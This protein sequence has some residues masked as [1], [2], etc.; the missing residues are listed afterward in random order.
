[1]SKRIQ[2]KAPP[3]VTPQLQEQIVTQE[4]EYTLITPLFGG[5]AIAGERD[6]VTVVRGTEIRGHLRFWWRACYGGRYNTVKEMK[7]DEDRIWGAAAHSKKDE[8]ERADAEQKKGKEGEKPRE[9]TVQITVETL[10]EG[11]PIGPFKIKPATR[12]ANSK[13]GEQR[14][15]KNGEENWDDE[16][17]PASKVP[18]YAAFPLQ[19]TSNE[20]KQEERPESKLVYDNVSFIL[21][22]SFPQTRQKEIAG[23]LWAW[24]TFG[25]IGARTR[26]GF[27]AIKLKKAILIEQ[28]TRRRIQIEH[29]L[30]IATA[31]DVRDWLTRKF[32]DF[33][34][35]KKAPG[36]V[37]SLSKDM[38][39]EHIYIM[40]SFSSPQGAW[41]ALIDKLHTFRQPAKGRNKQWPDTKEIRRLRN[42][43]NASPQQRYKFPK[44]VLGL[45]IA[46]HF[47]DKG[48][49]ADLTLQGAKEGHDRLASALILRPL[50]CRNNQ[51]GLALLLENHVEN[52]T[53]ST[54]TL[55]VVTKEQKEIPATI[56]TRLSFAEARDTVLR[57]ETDVWKAFM[58]HLRGNNR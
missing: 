20:R 3:A 36:G 26:R 41:K 52:H 7:Q 13:K 43:Q 45:P 42:T 50:A 53:F 31:K 27:G 25:G 11:E 47:A 48:K 23:T 56:E 12:K 19:L 37:P 21:T 24:E 22:I 40:P 17:N 28:E 51:V 55:Q 9:T 5:G 10:N 32:S 57:G 54:G 44:A 58:K 14:D 30:P 46:F 35:E 39:E 34:I 16:Y 1:M 2:P 18:E 15:Q 6:E 38:L 8:K 4:R 29:V 33:G 49:D